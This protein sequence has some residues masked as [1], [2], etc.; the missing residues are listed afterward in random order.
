MSY[1]TLLVEQTPASAGGQITTL[2]INRPDKL[3]ALSPVVIRELSEALRALTAE[4]RVVI[5]KGAGEKAFVAGADIGAMQTLS[6]AEAKA[7]TDQGHALGR[8]IEQLHCPVIAVVQGFALGG[9]CELALACDFIFASE[10][11]SFGQPEVNL[12]L[13]PGFGG[14]QRLTRRVGLGVARELVYTGRQIDAQE[15]LRI[16]LVNRVVPAEELSDAVMKTAELIAQKAPLAV[17]ACKRVMERGYDA[18]LTT[19]NELEATAFGALFGSEDQREGTSAF[20]ERRK[21]R[22]VGK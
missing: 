20:L 15:A 3:N 4:T 12:G 21:P 2:T 16:G 18:D 1:E 6:V 7:F 13:M 14:T 19:A 9:G 17:S 10:R 11:A 5:L 8:V 22:F